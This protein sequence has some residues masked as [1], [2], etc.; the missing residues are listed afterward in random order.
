MVRG[1]EDAPDRSTSDGRLPA[2]FARLRSMARGPEEGA[3]VRP[4]HRKR[5]RQLREWLRPIGRL[6]AVAVAMLALGRLIW[7]TSVVVK[8]RREVPGSP[9]YFYQ[10]D[11]AWSADV[12]GH[13]GKTLGR[14]GDAVACLAS[15]LAM[16]PIPAPFEGDVDPGTLNA[17]LTENDAY[18]SEGGLK[19]ER[20][21][22]L[23][24]VKAGQRQAQ[25]GLDDRIESLLQREIY[26][27]VTVRRPDTH[28]LHE[29]L[30]AGSVHGEFVIVDPLD[31]TGIPNSLALYGN[32]I[33]GLRYLENEEN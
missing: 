32:R 6:L 3:W 7:P 33:R 2:G 28:R 22:A 5:A 19:W 25:W 11:P 4:A 24:G 26:P 10:E 1:G 29:V 17:W 13:S 14:D 18:D 31:P 20:V 9:E 23:L 16:Q 12:M 21:A 30:V 8:A 27:I 15:L